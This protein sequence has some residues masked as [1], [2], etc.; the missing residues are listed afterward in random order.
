MLEIFNIL[1]K[2]GRIIAEWLKQN[3]IFID[4]ADKKRVRPIALTSC[5]G[6]IL[7][8]MVNERLI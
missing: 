5:M 4:K 8:R 1:Y 2:E 7:E 6:K 3:I